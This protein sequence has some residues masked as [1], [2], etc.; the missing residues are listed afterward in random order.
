MLV[1]GLAR[2][3]DPAGLR[4]PRLQYCAHKSVYR[5][6]VRFLFDGQRINPSQTPLQA[7][8]HTRPAAPP[9]GCSRLLTLRPVAPQL[10]ME[11]GDSVDAM[12]EQIGD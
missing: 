3:A 6:S 11:D 5:H 12:V 2:R 8:S 1:E 10:E 4:P 9:A 7:R